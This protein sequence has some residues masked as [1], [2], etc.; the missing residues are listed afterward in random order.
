[1]GR[2]RGRGRGRARGGGGEGE[3]LNGSMWDIIGCENPLP[4][5]SLSHLALPPFSSPALDRYIYAY[6]L[7][8][9]LD[10]RDKIPT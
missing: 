4:S 10:I 9:Y 1:M 7:G 2:A 8:K 3:G 5:S 6:S